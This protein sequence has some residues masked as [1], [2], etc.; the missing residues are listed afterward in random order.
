[1]SR[2]V[3]VVGAGPVGLL[4]ALC[5]ADR[6]WTPRVLARRLGPGGGSRAI[7]VHPPALELLGRLGLAERFLA[8]GVLVR[9][10]VAFGAH[11]ELGTVCFD[12]YRGVLSIPQE[13]TE[14]LLRAAL[15]EREIAVEVAEVVGVRGEGSTVVLADGSCIDADVVVACDGRRSAVRG[16]YGIGVTGGDYEGAFAMGDFPDSTPYGADAAVFLSGRGLVESFPLPDGLRRWVVRRDADDGAATLDELV[17]TIRD[18]TGFAV[19][20]DEA[21]TWSWFHAQHQLAESFAAGPV[22]LVGDAAHV[23]SPI[24]GQGMNLGWLGAAD[25]ARSLDRGEA[26]VA[27][28]ARRR[29]R[30][31]VAA[32]RRAELN[33]WLGRPTSHPEARDRLVRSLLGRPAGRVLARS[34]TMHDLRLGF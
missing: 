32:T 10:G 21:R 22:A 19:R 20:A 29:R 34:F 9:R 8:R 12:R 23:V 16:A 6:G 7:G 2:S 28:S 26:V 15:A 5:A 18:R 17:E 11:G 13:R 1:M 27:A 31:A 4:F 33:M 30:M 25:L 24:G 3:T 14:A